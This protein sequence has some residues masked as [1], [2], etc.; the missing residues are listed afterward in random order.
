MKC[1][2]CKHFMEVFYAYSGEHK[3]WCLINENVFKN[4]KVGNTTKINGYEYFDVV[5]CSKFT[6][7]VIE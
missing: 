5:K 1:I 7:G 6:Q 2:D 3:F 4:L